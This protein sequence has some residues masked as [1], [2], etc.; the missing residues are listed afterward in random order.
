MVGGSVSLQLDSLVRMVELISLAATT[1]T[2]L[3][4]VSSCLLAPQILHNLFKTGR[5]RLQSA[6]LLHCSWKRTQKED[7][8]NLVSLFFSLLCHYSKST[9]FFQSFV[10]KRSAD[11]IPIQNDACLSFCYR[12]FGFSCHFYAWTSP[13]N[14]T[15]S[16]ALT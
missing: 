9:C 10:H 5:P 12:E 16:L 3:V 4:D 13:F 15:S 11:C 14:H 7:L 2:F 8:L 6:V 1:A